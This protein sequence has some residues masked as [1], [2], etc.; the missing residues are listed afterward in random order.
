MNIGIDIDDTITDLS[1]VFFKYGKLYNEEK[2]ID[3]YIDKTMQTNIKGIY[4][5]GDATGHFRGAMQSMAS[6]ILIA[7]QICNKK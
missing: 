4:I 6:G 5:G 3:F 2:N 1:E 7:N